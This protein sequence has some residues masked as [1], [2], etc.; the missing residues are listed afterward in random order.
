MSADRQVNCAAWCTEHIH[1]TGNCTGPAVVVDTTEDLDLSAWLITTDAGEGA[2]RV[3]LDGRGI[4]FTLALDE[5]LRLAGVLVN[6]VAA[7]GDQ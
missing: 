1:E 3:V 5:A 7:G 6:G 2:T 4:S